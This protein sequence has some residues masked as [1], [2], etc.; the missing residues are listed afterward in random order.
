MPPRRYIDGETWVRTWRQAGPLLEAIRA[1]ELQHTDVAQFIR[2]TADLFDAL[3]TKG[4][5][6]ETSGLV[7]QQRILHRRPA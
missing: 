6:S 2:M 5:L 3:L 4:Q 1:E 7:D